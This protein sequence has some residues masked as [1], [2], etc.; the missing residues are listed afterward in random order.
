MNL[1]FLLAMPE[2]PVEEINFGM[3]IVKMIFFL[4]VVVALIYVVLKKF[5]PLLVHGSGFRT[6]SVKILERL[7]V[8]QR[9]SLLVVEVQDKVYLMGS[10][11]GQI[12]ILMELD[13]E[14]LNAKPVTDVEGSSGF[15]QILRKTF[16]R[17]TSEPPKS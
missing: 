17:K 3:L 7:P 14:K 13:G 5:L 10:A 12:N 4:G 1:I 8:D 15:E 9:R 6:R 11:E 16:L 2:P